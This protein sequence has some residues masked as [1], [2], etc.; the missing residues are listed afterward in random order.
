V[1][2]TLIE[3]TNHHLFAPLLYQVATGILSA[4]RSRPPRATC[5]ASSAM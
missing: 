3:R 4:A 5:C 2:V 1:Q